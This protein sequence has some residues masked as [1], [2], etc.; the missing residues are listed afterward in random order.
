MPTAIWLHFIKKKKKLYD[1]QLEILSNDT[2]RMNNCSIKNLFYFINYIRNNH[3]KRREY[4][5]KP[6]VAYNM[7]KRYP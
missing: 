2:H 5:V 7:S 1:H 3:P 6:F 4:T